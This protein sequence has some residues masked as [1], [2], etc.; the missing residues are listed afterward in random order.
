MHTRT[1]S[2]TIEFNPENQMVIV[3]DSQCPRDCEK[4]T[5]AVH[6]IGE[7]LCNPDFEC[8]KDVTESVSA[9]IMDMRVRCSLIAEKNDN[10]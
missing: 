1:K 7:V 6:R 4:I 9:C 8:N 10:L 3:W 5:G 2:T